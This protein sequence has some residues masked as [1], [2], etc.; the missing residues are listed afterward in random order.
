[1]DPRSVSACVNG[2]VRCAAAGAAMAAISSKLIIYRI[3]R[4]GMT[5]LELLERGAELVEFT[6]VGS[7]VAGALRGNRA[8]VVLLGLRDQCSIGSGCGR[9][10][11]CDRTRDARRAAKQ[12]SQA[13]LECLGHRDAILVRH[14]DALELRN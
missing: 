6:T 1:M 10:G 9:V 5:G 2:R 12:R 8:V 13:I 4:S 11:G 3:C 7:P 14:D